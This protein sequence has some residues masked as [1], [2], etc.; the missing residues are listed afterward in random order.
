M[1]HST[2]VAEG[3]VRGN[4]RVDQLLA[5]PS[6]A[7]RVEAIRTKMD[8]NDSDFAMNLA[9]VRRAS[10][11]T[12]VDLAKR[13]GV[14][15]GVVSRIEN[16]DDVLL[17]TLLSYLAAAGVQDVALTATV[18]GRRVTIDLAYARGNDRDGHGIPA[19]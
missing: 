11:L 14:T 10:E 1:T 2:P 7:R 13:L 8:A 5:D 15:Q 16:R 18:G 19:D 17:S 3:F 12:Q 6:R 9:T 4:S